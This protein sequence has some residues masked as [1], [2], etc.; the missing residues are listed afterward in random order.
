MAVR[1]NVNDFHGRIIN[2]K[3]HVIL[4]TNQR[5]SRSDVKELLSNGAVWRDNHQL[6]AFIPQLLDYMLSPWKGSQSVVKAG[7]KVRG[8][9]RKGWL[10]GF[11][12]LVNQINQMVDDDLDESGLDD[13]NPATKRKIRS[14]HSPETTAPFRRGSTY[15]SR[16]YQAS[17]P[18]TLL[19]PFVR[20]LPRARAT[21]RKNDPETERGAVDYKRAN[22]GTVPA[23][24]PDPQ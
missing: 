2:P 12:D 8:G 3:D 23:F 16:P 10:A 21:K 22:V 20:A 13:R 17:P 6:H 24:L 18:S 1:K 11:A 14:S 7:K 15:P 4:P 5:L 9:A 19:N